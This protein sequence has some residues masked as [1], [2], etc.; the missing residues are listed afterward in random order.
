M[1][2]VN[3]GNGQVSST[4]RTH[5]AALAELRALTEYKAF[6]FLERYVDYDWFSVRQS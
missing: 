1:Y 4:F 5:V 3:Y 6:A 2:R